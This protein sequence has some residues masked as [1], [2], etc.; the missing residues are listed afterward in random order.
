VGVAVASREIAKA[1]GADPEEA[2]LAGLLHDIGKSVILGIVGEEERRHPG[3][4]AHH[5]LLGKL[6]E[7]CHTAVGGRVAKAWK[8]SGSIAEAI[9]HHHALRPE[10]SPIVAVVSLANDV[11]GS[12]G[13]GV[14]RRRVRFHEHPAFAALHLHPE[15]SFRILDRLPTILAEAPEMADAAAPKPAAAPARSAP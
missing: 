12:L 13:I 9:E 14:P 3:A 1:C 4:H 6:L 2:F 5:E 15:T 8:T 7:D 11:C 10:S